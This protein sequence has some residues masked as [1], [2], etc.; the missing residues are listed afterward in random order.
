MTRERCLQE[1]EAQFS[2]IR[3]RLW[4]V[5]QGQSNGFYLHGPPGISKTHTVKT[6]LNDN[7]IP[8]E[9]VQGELT[10][11]AL[12]DVI[13]ENPD[14]VIVLD[15]V[16]AI[17]KDPKAVQILLAAL[18]SPPDGSRVR[19]VPYRTARGKRVVDF[20]GGVVAI[21]NLSLDEH[22]NGVIAALESRVDLQMLAPT[23]EQVEA[24]V[25]KIAMEGPAGVSAEDAVMVAEF[26]VQECRRRGTRLTVRLFVDNALRDF[27]MWKAG[28]LENHWTVLVRTTVAKQFVPQRQTLRGVSLGDQMEA[29]RRGVP[30]I[31]KKFSDPMERVRSWKEQIEAARRG[32][33]ANHKNF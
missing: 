33:T 7:S 4:G 1:I 21:S 30:A 19:K 8:F 24:M 9:Y 18:G 27:R 14:G 32:S 15:D 2:I 25:F 11:T 16:S 29:D 12:F 3:D 31:C 26:L 28:G 10:G 20:T 6:F 23:P 17:F 13:E 5:C 22:R